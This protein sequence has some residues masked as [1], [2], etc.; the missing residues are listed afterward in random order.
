MKNDLA[1]LNLKGNVKSTF[2]KS[3]RVIRTEG[4]N[5]E[6]GESIENGTNLYFEMGYPYLLF[7][8]EGNIIEKIFNSEKVTLK[9]NLDKQ[10]ILES[11]RF[12]NESWNIDNEFIYDEEG[13]LIKYL[14][15][16][17]EEITFSINYIR[18]KDKPKE[19]VRINRNKEG[20][21]VSRF[22]DKYDEHGNLIEEFSSYEKRFYVYNENGLRQQYLIKDL[23]GKLKVNI[24]YKYDEHK[25][26]IESNILDLDS[27]KENVY[28]YKYKY[29]S[30]NNWIEKVFFSQNNRPESLTTRK[31]EYYK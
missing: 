13:V 17:N 12:K 16:K 29:D 21:E 14:S 6:K 31:I 8:E 30:H 24:I 7:N 18:D 15:K 1:K 10:K 23:G 11:R 9:Y 26:L 27:K 5:F 20:E 3:F 2:E 28:R 25:N 22:Y 4:D 19:V